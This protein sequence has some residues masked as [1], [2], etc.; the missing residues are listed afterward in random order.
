MPM[1][2][3]NCRH[4]APKPDTQTAQRATAAGAL[5]APTP[6]DRHADRL[7]RP[8]TR[9]G[10][11]HYSGDD[12]GDSTGR[13]VRRSRVPAVAVPRPLGGSMNDIP[14][15][16]AALIALITICGFLALVAEAAMGC[17]P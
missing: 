5:T 15:R 3:G 8:R 7:Q 11:G 12:D 1:I 10:P 14:R 9:P 6:H 4:T 13:A 17:A 2:G 16:L